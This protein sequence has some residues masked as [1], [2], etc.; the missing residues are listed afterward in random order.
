VTD[1]ELAEAVV[2]AAAGIALE[3][4]G[5]SLSATAK[6]SPADIVTEVDQQAE[7]AAD[8][9]IA[10]HRPDD[11][12]EGEEGARREGARRWYVDALDGTLNYLNGLPGWCA[13]TALDDEVAAVYD[14]VRD[15]LFTAQRGHGARCNGEPIAVKD[16]PS[17]DSALIATFLHQPKIHLPGV[18][19]TMTALLT[20][21]GSVRMTGSGTLELAYVAAGRLHG[22]IQPG[23]YTWDW[24]PG[25]LLVTEAGG[26]ATR[27]GDWC[28]AGAPGT[29]EALKRVRPA[30]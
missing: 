9:L 16:A 4:R 15:E 23:T 26:R 11:G 28:I 3:H 14:P 22:W 21:A 13:A 29:Y 1:L 7:R 20:R 24:L 12:I 6:E 25:A 19:P 18:L 27:E 10:E 2:R 17:L 8:Q 5:R 30:T